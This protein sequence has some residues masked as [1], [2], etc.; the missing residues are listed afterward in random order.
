MFDDIAELVLG[1]VFPEKLVRR[2]DTEQWNMLND[3][4]ELL[5]RRVISEQLPP[6]DYSEAFGLYYDCAEVFVCRADF[7][8]FIPEALRFRQPGNFHDYPS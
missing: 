5:V 7:Q 2:R 8:E 4:T 1:R 3:A 6:C